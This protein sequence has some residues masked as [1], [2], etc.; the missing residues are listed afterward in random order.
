[1]KYQQSFTFDTKTDHN[2]YREGIL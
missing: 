2:I 1:L